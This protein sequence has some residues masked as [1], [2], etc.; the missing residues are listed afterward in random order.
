MLIRTYCS[1]VRQRQADET[2]IRSTEAARKLILGQ[3]LA[4]AWER[5]T[6][7]TPPIAVRTTITATGPKKNG[8]ARL[9]CLVP[10]DG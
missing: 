8:P 10:Q 2:P 3:S 7:L 6:W 4:S 1:L 5:S 9:Y